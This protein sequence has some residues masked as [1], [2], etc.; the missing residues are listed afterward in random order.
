ESQRGNRHRET[1][2]IGHTDGH[3]KHL[4][5]VGRAILVILRDGASFVRGER[6]IDRQERRSLAAPPPCAMSASRPFG[7]IRR[8]RETF[9]SLIARSVP[10]V[11]R[12]NG[13][14]TL[15]LALI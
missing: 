14:A 13:G 3:T 10:T 7:T 11:S 9:R 15:A 12:K 5:R 1:H 6:G 8:R 2:E 4:S